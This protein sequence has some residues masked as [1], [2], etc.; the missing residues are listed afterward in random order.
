MSLVASLL[1]ALVSVD[2]EALVMHASEKPYVI[3]PSGRVELASRGLT[4]A[5]VSGIVNQI[6][7][8]EYQNA[9]EEFG[10][11]QFVMPPQA[12][13]PR[14]KFTVVAARDDHDAWAEI[15]RL[16][17]PDE[18]RVSEDMFAGAST[19]RPASAPAPP[20]ADRPRPAVSSFGPSHEL[21][22]THEVV[23]PSIEPP[24]RAPQSPASS[25]GRPAP[26]SASSLQR[27]T[28]PSNLREVQ[29][30]ADVAAERPPGG[31]PRTSDDTLAHPLARSSRSAS[32]ARPVEPSS[33]QGRSELV[34]ARPEERRQWRR[35]APEEAVGPRSGL[36][37][38]LRVAAGRGAST[39]YL[40]SDARPSIRVDGELRVLENEPVLIAG[41]VVSL[42]L[43]LMPER[44]HE[45]LRT[46]ATTEWICDLE[47]MCRV[48]CMTFTDHRGPGGVFRL[49]AVRAAAAEELGLTR[50]IQLLAIEPEGLVLVTGPRSSGKRTLISSLVDLI[51]RGRRDH[52]ITLEREVN[53][54]H[55]RG[56][57]FISQRE[58]R[59]GD[60]EMLATSRAVLREDPD[61]LVLERIRTGAL[62]N[63]ALEAA[64][65][66]RLVIGGFSAHNAAESIDRIIDLYA[67]EYARQVQLALANQLRGIVA[68]VLL[69][70]R[71]GGRV[72]ARELLLNTPA[73]AGVIAEGKTSQLPMAIEGGRRQGMM[74]LDDALVGYVQDGVVDVR[75]AYR[76]VSDRPSFVALLQRRGI[77]T[78]WVSLPS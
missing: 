32:A 14:E 41:D 70:K 18:D 2:G 24:A 60:E 17:V 45:A 34:A 27:T 10:A 44:S 78:S 30:Q 21:G 39:L 58:V 64:A 43:T 11:V 23:R 61:V 68:Q 29:P 16:R 76:Q 71:G 50:E 38:L 33:G 77:D 52:V 7:P 8:T 4:L 35:L 20:P 3:A 67:P 49:M 6:L 53:I 26:A 5:A 1:H 46:G 62:M 40:S 59:G 47:D 56:N 42:L 55:P 63:V 54:V 15:R 36:D 57:S 13:L 28:A 75:E 19:L 72:A 51:N 74:P 12:G 66:G 73:V 48:R 25:R 9:L 37:R 31:P 65:E 22:P 69:P